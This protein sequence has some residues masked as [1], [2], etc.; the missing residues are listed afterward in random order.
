MNPSR[1]SIRLIEPDDAEALAAHLA[2]DATALARWDPE[3]PPDYYTPAGQRS[4]IED[5]LSRYDSGETWPGVVLADD[6]VIGRITA[7]GILRRAW[8]KAE[9]GYSIA[10]PYQGQGHATRAV[11]MMVQVMTAELKLHRA[12]AFTQMDNLGSQHVLRNNGFVPCGISRSHTF[13]AGMWRDEVL[14]ERLL[15]Q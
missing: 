13:I 6:V 15:D 1:T 10:Y 11:S 2:R 4:R 12:E 8:Q 9:L 3:R 7:Q 14:W 5:M